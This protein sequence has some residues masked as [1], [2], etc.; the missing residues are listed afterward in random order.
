ML[1]RITIRREDLQLRI[2]LVCQALMG[3]GVHGCSRFES[4]RLETDSVVTCSASLEKIKYLLCS[5]NGSNVWH[6]N[7][8]LAD[9]CWG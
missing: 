8:K 5:L 6:Q 1:L 4:F 2:G 7:V 9:I 3:Q